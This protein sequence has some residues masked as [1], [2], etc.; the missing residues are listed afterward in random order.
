[1]AGSITRQPRE[2]EIVKPSWIRYVNGRIKKKKNFIGIFTG[3][4]GSG[5]TYAA[6][7]MACQLDKNFG[8]RQIVFGLKGLMSLINS[9]GDLKIG[10]VILWDEVQVGGNA[11]NWQSLT[12]KLINLLLSTFRHKQ[13]ILLMTSP[14]S[15]FIDAS[16][17]KLIHAEFEVVGIDYKKKKTKVKPLL[18][19]YNSRIRKTFYK[20]LRIPGK[21]GVAKIQRWNID[22]PP[23]WLIAEYEKLKT[24]FTSEL[25]K[26]IADQ[27]MNEEFKGHDTRKSLTDKQAHI[28]ECL[29][30]SKGNA[31]AAALLADT[32]LRNVY[33][34][35]VAARNK[36]Y[37]WE[38]YA[39]KGV[40]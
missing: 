26:S 25:N 8:P 40:N 6:M 33:F 1:M 30:D 17:R 39:G 18:L 2:G 28:L 38:N 22:C 24:N 23:S 36:G 20:Y 5:K 27:L 12:N 4:T 7:S 37:T 11:K 32:T 34:H 19:Q 31:E 29:R 3:P 15:D 10:S 13:F 14:Y 21:I 35:Q 9:G 16:V